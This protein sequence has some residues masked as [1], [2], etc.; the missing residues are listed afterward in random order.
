MRPVQPPTIPER[1]GAG[2]WACFLLAVLGALALAAGQAG[3]R[4][5]SAQE[6][7]DIMPLLHAGPHPPPPEGFGHKL[8]DWLG[9]RLCQNL[10]R[11]SI[12]VVQKAEADD[13]SSQ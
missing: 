7:A 10:P 1:P 2:L 13:A 5:P 4:A 6:G 11:R 3:A 9:K 12:V 8:I